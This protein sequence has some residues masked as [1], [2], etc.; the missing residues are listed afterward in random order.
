MKKIV[1]C[2]FICFTSQVA[3]SQENLF[4]LSGGAVVAMPSGTLNDNVSI[5][6]GPALLANIDFS[7]HFRGF[8]QTG[9]VFFTSKSAS[10]QVDATDYENVSSSAQLLPF[11]AGVHLVENHFLIGGGIGYSNYALKET[12]NYQNSGYFPTQGNTTVKS[13]TS[14]FTYSPQIGLDYHKFQLIASY[15]STSI[16]GSDAFNYF[17]L[18]FYYK[19]LT[20]PL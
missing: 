19:F 8:I 9:Y 14:G 1:L 10:V 3:K 15:T 7:K 6:L 20:S 12:V 5:G 4:T 13:N 2:S 18:T 11:L 17:G 16:K